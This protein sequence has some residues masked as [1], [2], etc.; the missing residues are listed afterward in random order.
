MPMLDDLPVLD[1]P[2]RDPADPDVLAGPRNAEELA[3]MFAVRGHASGDLVAF[4]DEVFDYVIAGRASDECPEGLLPVVPCRGQSRERVVL[5]EVR[6]EKLVDQVG[7]P[8]RAG[9]VD[10]REVPL[11][12]HLVVFGRHRS[13]SAQPVYCT[14][15]CRETLDAPG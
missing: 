6:R 9:L 10:R 12:E 11:D 5:D 1:P 2:D 13:P 15:V 3:L 7:V 4:G 14:G 8:P